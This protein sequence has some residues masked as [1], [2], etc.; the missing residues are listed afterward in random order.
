M[1][2][3]YNNRCPGCNRLI[4]IKASQSGGLC[5][6]C[7]PKERGDGG[8]FNNSFESD[9][10]FSGSHTPPDSFGIIKDKFGYEE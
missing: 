4:S 3:P 9:F 10:G 8:M 1:P 6:N 5:P 2:Q 7:K